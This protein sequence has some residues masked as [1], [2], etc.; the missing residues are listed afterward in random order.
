MAARAQVKG[1]EIACL[2]HPEIDLTLIGDP[3]RLRQILVNLVGNAIKFTYQ[4]EIVIQAEPIE[5][6]DTFALVHFSVQDTGIGIPLDRQAAIFDRFTQADGSTT[7]NYGGT[8]LG[9]TICKQLAEAMDGK[10]GVESKP[11][12]GSNFWFDLKFGKQSNK[13]GDTAPLS[14]QLVNTRETRILIVDDNK[15][16]QLVLT[17]NVEVIG[18]RMSSVSSGAK[19]LESLRNAYR[20]GDPYHVVLLDMQMPGMDGEQT[21]RAIKSD[22]SVK[23]V[24]IIILT[25]MGHRGDAARMESLGC[26]G[27]LLEPVKQQMLFEAILAVLGHESE[28]VPEL[29]TRHTISEQRKRNLRLLL[30]EDNSINQKL[31]LAVLQK[32]GYSADTVDTGLDAVTRAKAHAYSA[33][34]MD[35]Q[36]PVMDGLEATRLIREWEKEEDRE[37]IPIIAM[38]AHAMQGDRERCLEAGMDDYITKPL[39]PRVL[40][41]ALNRWLQDESD[42]HE[43]GQEIEDYSSGSESISFAMDDG[44]FGETSD[45]PLD[46]KAPARGQPEIVPPD[47]S[48][49]DIET[50]IARFDDDGDFVMSIINEFRETL[51]EKLQE[52]RQ[53]LQARDSNTLCRQAHNLKGVS[54]NVCAAP[55]AEIALHL[56][57][58]ALRDELEFAEPLVTQ[59]ELE[60]ARL[61]EF[62]S[63]IN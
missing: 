54:L 12:V 28:D 51:P 22:P 1:L 59:L 10:I 21:A 23:A 26:S 30:V 43:A 62:L 18:C 60:S 38:T 8:G 40:F 44:L 47:G 3:G 16:N 25:S 19:A 27:Y 45:T 14:P 34:L 48:P 4:G 20:A 39:Q 33:I 5:Q 52:I 53:S 58:A 37:R 13:A 63:N 49:I 61:E 56:E 41:S 55:L 57:N 50:A 32:A 36:M 24:K 17:K 42:E 2:I 6:S 7:R 29:I 46:D 31:A 11:G 15:T 9:L 35:V